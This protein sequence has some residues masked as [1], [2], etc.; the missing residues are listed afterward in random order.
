MKKIQSCK[1]GFIEG[2]TTLIDNHVRV[3]ITTEFQ[4]NGVFKNNRPLLLE[5]N[6]CPQCG[7]HYKIVFKEGEQEELPI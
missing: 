3:G 7:K 2:K 6:Y 1:C 5:N 4:D